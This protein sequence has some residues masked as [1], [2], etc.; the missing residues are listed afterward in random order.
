MPTAVFG[1]SRRS[2]AAFPMRRVAAVGLFALLTATGADAQAFNYPS[3]QLPQ[4]STRDYT[5]ALSG[6][7]GST[8]LFQ[9]R[10][11]WGVNRHLQLD[12]G[13]ADRKGDDNLLLI[14]G[15]AFGQELVRASGDQPLDLLLSAGAGASFGSGVSLIR[16]PMGVSIGHTFA[17]EQGMSL[18]PYLHP[19]ASL[20]LCSSC[21]G[22]RN[23]RSEVSLNFD[24]GVNYQVNREF[25]LRVAGSFS[26]SDL[27]GSEDTFAIGFNW[28]PRPLV[29]GAR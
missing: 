22:R 4:A 1:S 21:G 10:E 16:L 23:G 15:G 11:G 19:R 5:A 6:G 28:T 3:M 2:F 25:A 13:L 14:V 26:G 17:L 9:W 24:L 8:A 18:T 20:D 7:A 27:F 29:R 12:L